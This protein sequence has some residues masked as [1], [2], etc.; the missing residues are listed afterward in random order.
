MDYYMSLAHES[1]PLL[2]SAQKNIA[3]ADK[4]IEIIK[5][6]NMPTVA[7]FGGYTL[8]RPI[9]T[10]N[11]VLD[12]YSGGWQTGV[13]LSYNIDA[14][15]KTKEKVKLGELQKNQANDAMTLVQQ[16][17]DMGVSDYSG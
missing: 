16:N 3:V 11:P 7:G 6:D 17:V 15:Y 8:Q 5:T 13:S 14:L 4:N 10:R 9:T 2:K 12:M 1:N